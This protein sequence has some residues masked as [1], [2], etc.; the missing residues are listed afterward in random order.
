MKI[1]IPKEIMH[2]ETRVSI[3]PESVTKLTSQNNEVIVETGAG[4]QA[5]YSDKSYEDAGATIVENFED[6]V[7]QAD[8]V[9]KVHAPNMDKNLGR[10]ETDS[11]KDGSYLIGL[12]Q[13]LSNLDL[14]EKL[15]SKN[16]TSFSLDAIPRIARAQSM[17]V[18]S[19]M[20]SLAGY[21]SAIIA[22]NTLEKY[23]PMMMTAAGTYAPAKGLVLGAGVAGLQAI[24]TSKRLGA[25]M[26]A[27]DVRPVVKEQVESLGAVFVGVT[28][29]V[30]IEDSGGY[31]KEMTAD[32]HQKELDLIHNYAKDAD[33]I[34]TTALI[35]GK[36]APILLTKDIVSDMKPGSIVI[37]IAAESGGNCELTKPG[38]QIIVNGVTI[39][40]PLN[41]PS[42]MPIHAS[43]MYS[44][45]LVNLLDH[46]TNDGQLELDLND[47]IT[48]GCCITNHGEI[49]NES[50]KAVMGI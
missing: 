37:D 18:L 48:S 31:A 7:E 12:L 21:K 19:S 16:I 1:A 17:D 15:R 10:I 50:T 40:G 47:I 27:F 23:F 28:E 24:A 13:P 8:I 33:F 22:A 11:L 39:L 35:P 26:Q 41:L 14:I 45:N 3:V 4:K 49:V 5:N 9:L 46:L 44:R 29:E 42:T 34:I 36:P 25:V 38:E 6:L 2:K 32:S 30:N 20:S 43:Q